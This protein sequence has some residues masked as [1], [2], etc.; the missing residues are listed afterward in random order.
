M[1]D[2]IWPILALGWGFGGIGLAAIGSLLSIPELVFPGIV[3]VALGI[4]LAVCIE[5]SRAARP[6]STGTTESQADPQ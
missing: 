5:H 2:P 1:K 6:D 3:L 4:G